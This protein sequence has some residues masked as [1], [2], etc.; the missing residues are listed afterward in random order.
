MSGY[1]QT[2]LL[3]CNRLSSVE[4]NAS[5]LSDS[6][7]SLF[8]NKVANG[9][10]LDVGD[11]V[12]VNSAYISE[13]GAGSSVI[14]FKGKELGDNTKIN[15]VSASNDLMKGDYLTTIHSQKDMVDKL[16]QKWRKKSLLEIMK[17]QLSY[18]II[19]IQMEI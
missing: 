16:S 1:T 13:R 11:Q 12:S 3:D 10:E 6:D 9:L 14:E 19:K 8:T 7:K 17:Y 18:S 4:Y 15:Y 2:L 5:K